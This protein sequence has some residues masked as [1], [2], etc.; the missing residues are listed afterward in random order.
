[1]RHLAI[2]WLALLVLSLGSTTLSLDVIP[3]TA[4]GVIL[5]GLAL[6]KARIILSDYLGLRAAPFWRR[7]FTFVLSLYVTVLFG[8]YLAA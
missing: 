7:G 2:A 8:L 3:T 1:M 5:L 4:T 6:L